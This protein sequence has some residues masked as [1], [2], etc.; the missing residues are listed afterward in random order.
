MN[1]KR[2]HIS[3]GAED[4]KCEIVNVAQ[5]LNTIVSCIYAVDRNAAVGSH[6][7]SM[8]AIV[9]VCPE[10][11][12][13]CIRVAS[14][15]LDDKQSGHKAHVVRTRCLSQA[16]LRMRLPVQPTAAPQTSMR[17][18]AAFE[19]ISAHVVVAIL[20]FPTPPRCGQGCI[21]LAEDSVRDRTGIARE[22]HGLLAPASLGP[23]G[24]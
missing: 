3:R 15:E 10:A 23:A 16:R 12:L 17:G 5:W 18:S 13:Q 2:I 9:R 6:I 1:T 4:L 14:R 19:F 20:H 8:V 7:S 24:V 11:D 21:D 22:L